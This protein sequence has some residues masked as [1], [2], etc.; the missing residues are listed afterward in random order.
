MGVVDGEDITVAVDS[1]ITHH[2]TT[3]YGLVDNDRRAVEDIGRPI[4]HGNR[5]ICGE[6][7]ENG[8]ANLGN[9]HLTLCIA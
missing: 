4:F 9:S 8:I 1:I 2:I 3:L 7:R 5:M 6:Q